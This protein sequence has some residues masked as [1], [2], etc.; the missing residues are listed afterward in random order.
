V[1]ELTCALGPDTAGTLLSE[2]IEGEAQRIDAAVFE[3]GRYYGP[4]FLS[5]VQRGASVRLLLDGHG[6]ANPWAI[7]QLRRSRGVELGTLHL[8]R[9]E[10]H[11]KVLTAGA[12]GIAIGSGNLIKYDAPRDASGRLPPPQDEAQAGTREWWVLARGVPEVVTTARARIDAAWRL[13]SPAMAIAG[14]GESKVPEV[15]AP[16]PVVAPLRLELDPAA[17]DSAHTGAGLRTIVETMVTQAQRRALITVPYV[18]VTAPPVQAVLL[19][20]ADLRGV[21]VRILI[22]RVPNPGEIAGIVTLGLKA[23]VMDAHRSTTGHAKGV[24]A[25]DSVL[26]MS[27]NFSNAGL[28]T[29][30]EAGMRIHSDAAADYY[31][32]CFDRDWEVATPAE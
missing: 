30:L 25:D 13:A 2:F 23:R 4:C 28:T 14:E 31:A 17:L 18:H 12:G 5:A 6:A 10:A 7:A 24:V 22:G 15:N 20:L 9:R 11:W 29:N 19:R 1:A 3:V 27:A 16:H 32:D 26:V 8:G 21:D